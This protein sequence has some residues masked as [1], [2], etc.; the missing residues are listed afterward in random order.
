MPNLS[1]ITR[2]AIFKNYT[3]W[4]YFNINQQLCCLR[5]YLN[6]C[7]VLNTPKGKIILQLFYLNIVAE[8]D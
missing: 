7:K 5:K 2:K 4:V 1:N 3:L 6:A 8:A